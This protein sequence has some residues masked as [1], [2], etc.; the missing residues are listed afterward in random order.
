MQRL[1]RS[2]V[3]EERAIE[4]D[5]VR[6][7]L[8]VWQKEE[9]SYIGDLD[10]FVY[11]I[12]D[13]NK[14]VQQEIANA[15]KQVDAKLIAHDHRWDK[16]LHHVQRRFE[17]MDPNAENQDSTESILD[18][19]EL[20]LGDVVEYRRDEAKALL[21]TKVSEID[22]ALKDSQDHISLLAVL[23]VAAEASRHSSAELLLD[24]YRELVDDGESIQSDFSVH[25][26]NL[27]RALD[28]ANC[29]NE[30]V[31]RIKQ[32]TTLVTSYAQGAG[33]SKAPHAVSLEACFLAPQ[34][35][36]AGPPGL[37][38]CQA[39]TQH[40]VPIQWRGVRAAKA[41]NR[42]GKQPHGATR[43]YHADT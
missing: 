21:A 27:L 32:A 4:L 14:L 40:R 28:S 3:L 20:R 23:L 7:S 1:W 19:M 36:V 5:R 39:A 38:L 41:N 15:T 37:S 35:Y 17:Q 18:D 11:A 33:R 30:V 29:S 43:S 34:Q 25:L 9:D 42:R 31:S 16:I 12:G 22:T 24:D 8:N 10:V 6:N 2:H 13:K 26:G